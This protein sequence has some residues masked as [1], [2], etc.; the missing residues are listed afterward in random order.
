MNA[1]LRSIYEFFKTNNALFVLMLIVAASALLVGDRFFK[2]SNVFNL[3]QT[4]GT[5]GILAAGLS[6]VFIVGGIDLSIG[7][8]VAF[9]GTAFAMLA[10]R[11]GFFAA[12]AISI[13]AG[14][15]IGYC[16]GSIVTR[17]GI[18]SLIGTLAVMTVLKGL[19]LLIN[20]AGGSKSVRDVLLGGGP[21]PSFYNMK[22]FGFLSPSMLIA[23]LLF[24]AFAVFL[25][26]TRSGVGMY[27][28][29]GNPE[30]AVLSGIDKDRIMRLTYTVCGFCSAVCAVL[31]V[32][33]NNASTYNMGDNIDIVAICS[34]VIGGVRMTG[35]RGNMLMCATGV[36]IIQ[37]I[38]N[39]MIKIGLQTSVQALIMGI[40]VII[41]L[42]IN[43][44]TSGYEEK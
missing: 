25:K 2:P 16:N 5:F 32:I 4:I 44:I 12:A 11:L 28:I 13:A 18:P 35:G 7:Y 22:I 20:G 6:F 33:R 15:L 26:W 23:L 38:N 10:P 43:K 3:L 27:V 37:M 42:I 34:V 29:G 36:A 9:C 40:I 8:Q 30:A 14:V 21:L 24:C 31:C 17:L 1:K 39:A 19:V 41:V